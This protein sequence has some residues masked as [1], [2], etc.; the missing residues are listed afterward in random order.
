MKYISLVILLFA[1]IRASAQDFSYTYEG[2]RLTY[3]ILDEEAKTCEVKAGDAA[4][5]T[6]ITN[7]RI[8]G[9]IFIPQVAKYG[10]DCYTVVAIGAS[11]FYECAFMK[12]V[13]VPN[14]VK[15]IGNN[16][17][18]G[19]SN[20]ASVTLPNSLKRIGDDTYWNAT[21]IYPLGKATDDSYGKKG[22]TWWK[23]ENYRQ[24][25]FAGYADTK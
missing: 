15:H 14:S 2:K 23:F 25:N 16:A 5:E 8:S 4:F 21:L 7:N 3:T 12:S 19:C 18:A 11:A 6:S 17:F 20:L 13:V 1:C 9:D 22:S 10:R 24:E